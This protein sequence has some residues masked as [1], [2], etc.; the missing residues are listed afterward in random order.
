MALLLRRRVCFAAVSPGSFI[1]SMNLLHSSIRIPA[2]APG[3]KDEF[4]PLVIFVSRSNY[5]TLELGNFAQLRLQHCGKVRLC[6]HGDLQFVG[7]AELAAGVFPGDDIGGLPADG[8]AGFSAPAFNE[9]RGLVSGE[10][11]QRAGDWGL[12]SHS[13]I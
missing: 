13:R 7:L 11:F 5:R 9:G 10:A 8:G 4:R 12:S 2:S 3:V 6:Q 1:R